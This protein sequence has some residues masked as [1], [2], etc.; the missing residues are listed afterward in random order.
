MRRAD[1]G[2][3][4]IQLPVAAAVV[5]VESSD[6]QSKLLQKD[7]PETAHPETGLAAAETDAGQAAAAKTEVPTDTQTTAANG[8]HPSLPLDSKDN[9]TADS[10]PVLEVRP[11]GIRLSRYSSD[12][13]LA[14]IM[15][16]IT[17]ELSEPYSIYTYRYFIQ[18]WPDL[19]IMAH[20][21][22]QLIGVVV[23]K[24]E[25]HDTNF[26]GYLAMLSV[27]KDYRN[28]KLGTHLVR[29]VIDRM[30]ERNATEVVLEAELTNKGALGLY[31]N[32]GFVRDKFLKGYYLSGVDAY[33]LKLWLQ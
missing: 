33:R 5:D 15:D 19:C 24:L 18:S 9:Q 30:I 23:S 17:S 6:A 27:R 7:L 31:E 12:E 13:Q 10:N 29:K 1:P 8:H 32:L 16:L 2:K 20:D 22:D 28:R 3:P 21:G 25:M 4:Q 26:R 11:D 14:G